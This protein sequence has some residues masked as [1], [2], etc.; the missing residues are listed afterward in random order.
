[1]CVIVADV[2]L[3]FCDDCLCLLDFISCNQG[4]QGCVLVVKAS[5]ELSELLCCLFSGTKR[6]I[7]KFIRLFLYVRRK[8][9][10]TM[11]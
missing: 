3:P 5:T 1:M 9:N 2:R 6:T 7:F 10:S 8:S 4:I 11:Q